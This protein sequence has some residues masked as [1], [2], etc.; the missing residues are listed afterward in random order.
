MNRTFQPAVPFVKEKLDGEI[1]VKPCK[2]AH[3]EKT[4]KLVGTQ[5]KI[6]N[7]HGKTDSWLRPVIQ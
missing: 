2:I 1:E 6:V 4:A 5:G 3:V 7:P